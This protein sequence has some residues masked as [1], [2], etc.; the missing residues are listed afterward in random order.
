MM[1]Y[2][3]FN[4]SS[5]RQVPNTELRMIGLI[6]D[7]CHNCLAYTTKVDAG[8]TS[9]WKGLEHQHSPTSQLRNWKLRVLP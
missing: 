7:S 5:S 2:L 4:H 1:N 8:G 9:P 6:V 3:A